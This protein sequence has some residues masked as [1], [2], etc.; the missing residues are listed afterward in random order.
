MPTI[1]RKKINL[2]YQE[3]LNTEI[4]KKS[5]MSCIIPLGSCYLKNT[6]I[7]SGQTGIFQGL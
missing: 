1:Y 4:I 2:F 6:G 5:G 3:K 7:L